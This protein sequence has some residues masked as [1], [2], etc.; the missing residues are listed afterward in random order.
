MNIFD[1]KYLADEGLESFQT[2]F[3]NACFTLEHIHSNNFKEGDW[4]D[5]ENAEWVL[6][7][8]GEAQIAFED[9][10]EYLLAGDTLFIKAHERHRIVHTSDNAHWIALHVKD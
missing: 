6:L 10:L 2:L 9:R 7:V 1:T 8:R 4:Y 5:Q 3:Q